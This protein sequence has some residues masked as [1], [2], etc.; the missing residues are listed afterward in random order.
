MFFASKCTPLINNNVLSYSVDYNS[1]ARRSSINF[2]NLDMLKVIKSRNVHKAHGHDI[3]VRMIRI[4]GQSLVKP[5]AIIFKNCIDSGIF[6]NI[7]NKSNIISVHKKGDKQTID[8]YRPVSPL[9]ICGKMFEKLL[10]NSIIKVLDNNLFSSNQ[11][12][13]RPLDSCEYQFLSI[14]HDIYAFDCCPSLEVRGIF[15][16]ISKAFDGIKHEGLIFKLQSL[17]ISG[18]PLKCIESFLSNRCR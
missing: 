1:T 18:L 2:N 6:L 8:N 11:S 10:S 7:L 5:L 15:L 14:V 4:C 16:D 13:F 17:G 12:G 9:P 3:S